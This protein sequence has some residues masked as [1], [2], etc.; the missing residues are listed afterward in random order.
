MRVQKGDPVRFLAPK[1]Y[2]R[3]I[4]HNCKPDPDRGGMRKPDRDASSRAC[5]PAMAEL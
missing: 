3:D 1:T 4:D 2:E 5:W